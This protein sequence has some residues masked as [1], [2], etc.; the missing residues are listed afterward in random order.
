[1]ILGHLALSYS[2]DS[3]GSMFR[4]HFMQIIKSG[5]AIVSIQLVREAGKQAPVQQK[6]FS[7]LYLEA[8]LKLSLILFGFLCSSLS[9][10]KTCCRFLLLPSLSCSD[11]LLQP[12]ASTS[13]CT[14]G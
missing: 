13:E 1:M 9:L 8:V 2:G 3:I 6:H 7:Y 11:M 4:L 12:V 10:L 14:L 5:P